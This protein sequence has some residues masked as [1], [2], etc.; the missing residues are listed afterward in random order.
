[1]L[2]FD[3]SPF[4]LFTLRFSNKLVLAPFCKRPKTTQR[5]LFLPFKIN[6]CFPITVY[7]SVGGLVKNPGNLHA[8]W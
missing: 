5:T 3:K 8:T 6:N 2:A 1:V 4:E 7:C